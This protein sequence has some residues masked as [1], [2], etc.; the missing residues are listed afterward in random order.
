MSARHSPAAWAAAAIGGVM[1][2]GGVVE[3][4]LPRVVLRAVA[5]APTPELA[6]VLSLAGA[7]LALTGAAMLAGAL[8]TPPDRRLLAWTAAVKLCAPALLACGL[9]RGLVGGIAPLVAAYDL[10]TAAFVLVYA[11]R[12][13]GTA[14]RPGGVRAPRL[15][16]EPADEGV[17]A[18]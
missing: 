11:L 14:A 13:G 2:A 16:Q 15:Y 7:M 3:S 10:L 5:V 4:L 1:A 6:L 17:P 8:A 18:H 9:A 12:G